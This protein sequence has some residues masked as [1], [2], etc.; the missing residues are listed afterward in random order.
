MQYS[1]SYKGNNEDELCSFP[2]EYLNK[3]NEELSMLAIIK[4]SEAEAKRKEIEN[5]KL[6]EQYL[7]LKKRFESDS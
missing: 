6:Y 4:Q 3:P 7:A 2:I 1:W 5:K